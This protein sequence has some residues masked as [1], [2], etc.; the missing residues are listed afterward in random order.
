LD[1]S[2]G[3]VHLHNHTEYSILD[4]AIRIREMLARCAEY[5]MGACAITDHGALFGAVDFYLACKKAGIK[6]IIGCELYVARTR[7]DDKSAR[8]ASAAY[9]H[10]LVLCENETGYHNLCRLS[11]KGYLEGFHYKPR[12]DDALL[13]QY[14]EGLIAATACLGRAVPRHVLNDDLEAAETTIQKYV[15]I[16]GQ[17]SFLIEL[18]DHGMPEERQ[19]NPIL[20]ELAARHGLKTIA[21]N[22]CHYLDKADVKAHDALLCVQTNST[23]E[24]A[25]RLRFPSEEF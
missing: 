3:F 21:T 7:R 8:T 14:H 4:G 25:N 6:P 20:V 15:D 1:A 9:D 19:V 17:D 18:M 24:D 12:V 11:S 10:L 22:D 23:I 2:R 5:G 13:A 16:F